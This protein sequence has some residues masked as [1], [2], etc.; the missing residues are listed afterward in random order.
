MC[1]ST[2][3]VA[4]RDGYPIM[5]NT[6][7]IA[8]SAYSS[9]D[10]ITDEQLFR[11]VNNIPLGDIMFV[12][13]GNMRK[14]KGIERIVQA[15]E[16]FQQ[17]LVEK[18]AHLYIIGLA[19]YELKFKNI[20][21]VNLIQDRL[22]ESALNSVLSASDASIFN[23]NPDSFLNSGSVMKSLSLGIPV[24]A[25]RIGCLESYLVDDFSVTFN[26][27]DFLGL[28][29]ALQEASQRLVGNDK[30]R[31]AASSFAK[32]RSEQ[33]MSMLFRRRVSLI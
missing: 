32:T 26:S 18:S 14:Y 13:F 4:R 9:S 6:A 3:N 15:F 33:S 5:D 25:P 17:G 19:R 24:I 21:G 11:K 8:H 2:L 29:R 12:V 23:F 31:K 1:P 20:P 7:V 28:E 16:R 22:S 27:N 10:D 30:A